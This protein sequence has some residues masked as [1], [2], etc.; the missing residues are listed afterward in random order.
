MKQRV[1][2]A[3][4]GSPNGKQ[5][6]ALGNQI[7][8]AFDAKPVIA[9]RGG[10]KVP[11]MNQGYFKNTADKSPTKGLRM[12]IG[13]VNPMAVV[14]GATVSES[15]G[16]GETGSGGK[17][18]LNGG[19]C[20]IAVAPPDAREIKGLSAICVAVDGHGGADRAV[21]EAASMARFLGVGLRI[22]SVLDSAPVSDRKIRSKRNQDRAN[23]A[24]RI[25][26]K[27]ANRVP[28]DVAVKVAGLVG[29]PAQM[30]SDYSEG[31]DLLVVGSQAH[32]PIGRPFHKS[33]SSYLTEH[34]RCPVL[35]TPERMSDRSMA[36]A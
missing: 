25:L 11:E 23:N 29:D 21:D 1:I 22:V 16:R 28:A 18:I 33:I 26:E 10:E 24:T 17:R 32:G 27:A 13:Q 14:V 15:Y 20:P 31:F 8:R 7:C 4:D 35:I 19:K 5:A 30:L 12:L 6:L 9:Y 3:Y 2:I 36:F 34:A